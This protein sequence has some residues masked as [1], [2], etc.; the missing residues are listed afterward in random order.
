MARFFFFFFLSLSQFSNIYIFFGNFPKILEK[1]IE[2]ILR[3]NTKIPNFLVKKASKNF[4]KKKLVMVCDPCWVVLYFLEAPSV[5]VLKNKIKSERF[6]F[7]TTNKQKSPT[8][9]LSSVVSS[10]HTYKGIQEFLRFQ[11][12]W[13]LMIFFK[14]VHKSGSL[15]SIDSP[16]I[17]FQNLKTLK[18]RTLKIAFQILKP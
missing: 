9:L 2:F 15:P 4:I 12:F 8:D 14:K 3:K 16:K 11:G 1:L 7:H 5:L 18:T 10:T 17:A 13:V 6:R